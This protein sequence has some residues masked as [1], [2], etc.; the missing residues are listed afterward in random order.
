L[1]F[2][3]EKLRRAQIDLEKL[4]TWLRLEE[5]LEQKRLH[6]ASLNQRGGLLSLL[7]HQTIYND[8]LSD[9]IKNELEITTKIN[10]ANTDILNFNPIDSSIASNSKD[11]SINES[12][13][14][15]I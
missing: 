13:S 3:W 15:T 14:R 8:S 10:E 11:I 1:H 2:K 6:E 7:L 9:H 5:L 4:R 12:N